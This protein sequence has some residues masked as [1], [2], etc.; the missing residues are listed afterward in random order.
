ME[1]KMI[2]KSL[3]G[4]KHILEKPVHY[5]VKNTANKVDSTCIGQENLIDTKQLKFSDIGN[6]TFYQEEYITVE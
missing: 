5:F 1:K 6:S 4:E 2:W 3:L